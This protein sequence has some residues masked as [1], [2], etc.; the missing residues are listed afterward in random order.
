MAKRKSKFKELLINELPF[1]PNDRET[2]ENLSSQSIL[3][4]LCHYLSWKSRLIPQRPRAVSIEGSFLLDKRYIKIKDKFE[5][6]LNEIKL[7]NDL[8]FFLSDKVNRKGYTPHKAS[9]GSK[10]ADKDFLLNL[11]GFHHLHLE[12][13]YKKS[14]EEALSG[15]A[16]S[17]RSKEMIF[18]KVT[19]NDFHVIGIFDH[20]VFNSKDNSSDEKDSDRS[21]LMTIHSEFSSRGLP[22]DTVMATSVQT[23]SCHPLFIV[24]LASSYNEIILNNDPNLDDSEFLMNIYKEVGISMPRKNKLS[25]RIF[26]LDLGILDKDE[27]FIVFKKGHC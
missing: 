1:F 21:K 27:Q 3:S 16:Y 22:I 2:K 23:T 24:D 17:N 6:L 11:T 7:G 15:V 12:R 18:A 10:W 26:G 25:W 14:K 13:Y 20:S 4:V 9:S 8:T 5:L 19:R